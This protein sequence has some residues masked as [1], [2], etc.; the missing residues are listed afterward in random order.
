M[1]FGPF[2]CKA[3]TTP[4]WFL[5]FLEVQLVNSRNTFLGLSVTVSSVLS[6]LL[7]PASFFLAKHL[8]QYVAVRGS[9]SGLLFVGTSMTFHAASLKPRGPML[10]IHYWYSKESAV[11]QLLVITVMWSTRGLSK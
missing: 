11:L 5:P 1:S 7:P 6:L 9:H 2:A 3:L 4:E 8:L 10:R